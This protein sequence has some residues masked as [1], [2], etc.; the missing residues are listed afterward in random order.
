MIDGGG[1]K[2]APSGDVDALG[3]V[4]M[5]VR[6]PVHATGRRKWGALAIGITSGVPANGS[7]RVQ[8]CANRVE[9]IDCG[10]GD[11]VEQTA[12]QSVD[13][14]GWVPIR[15]ADAQHMCSGGPSVP[16]SVTGPPNSNPSDG[17]HGLLGRSLDWITA[18]AIDALDPVGAP[19][20]PPAVYP[21][22]GTPLV[23]PIANAPSFD[24]PSV[25]RARAPPSTPP[26]TCRHHRMERT[27][28]RHHRWH[29]SPGPC[30]S[31]GLL[32][33]EYPTKL[34][35]LIG[36]LEQS[37]SRDLL[38]RM[39]YL[40]HLYNPGA[41]KILFVVGS[42][43][44]GTRG[45]DLRQHLAIWQVAADTADMFPNDDRRGR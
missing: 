18:A 20:H 31:T 15:W 8:R 16:I 42:P 21:G 44:R 39:L 11:P 32:P 2:F 40:T 25:D 17:I 41:E 24:G 36:H 34:A 5:E 27:F 7:R 9:R 29:S 23:I 37:I 13:A 43:M 26:P 6:E 35:D 10:C 33:H 19:L 22:A 14:V 4:L 30:C 45:D 38:Y 12:E 28:C 3:V 1:R